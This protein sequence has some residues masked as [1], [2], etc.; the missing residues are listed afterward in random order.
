MTNS[1]DD[2]L[3][4]AFDSQAPKFEVAPVQSDPAALARLVDE[5]GFPPDALVLDAGCGPGLVSR[6]LLDAGCRV[7]GV[8]L[9]HEM[10]ERARNRCRCD[11]ERARFLQ[12]SVFDG[13]LDPLAPFDAVL[14]R[15]VLHHVESAQAFLVRQIDLLR[16]GG[17]VVVNDHVTD[18]DPAIAAHHAAIEIARDRTH[19]RNLTGGELVDLFASAGL[20]EIRYVEEAFTLDF[21]EWFDRGTPTEA[22]AT[23]RSRLLDGP[24]TRSFQ[25]QLRPDGSIQI[26]G[27]RAI[28]R[29]I[30]AV[31]DPRTERNHRRR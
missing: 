6:A 13:S 23:V 31:H 5:A 3:A 29:G 20:I 30:K 17:I 14:S 28:V 19:T 22:K 11:D 8:D 4:R 12:I 1:H 25:P 10:I 24:P 21:D 18:P 2:N 16:P 26:A 9:S 27:V 15:Y 7:V